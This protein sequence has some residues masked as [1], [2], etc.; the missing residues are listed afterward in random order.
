MG[1]AWATWPNFALGHDVSM[2]LDLSDFQRSLSSNLVLIL[3]PLLADIT[4]AEQ[5]DHA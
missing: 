4:P 3:R 1:K 2:S 5:T